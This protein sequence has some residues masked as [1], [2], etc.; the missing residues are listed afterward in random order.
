VTR[1]QVFV[2]VLLTIVLIASA[3]REYRKGNGALA[4]MFA[5]IPIAAWLA[6]MFGTTG[7]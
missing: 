2:M 1:T 5:A 3:V 7:P 6:L 4:A